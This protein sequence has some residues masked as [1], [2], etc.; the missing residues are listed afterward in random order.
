MKKSTLFTTIIAALILVLLMTAL[1]SCGRENNVAEA[2]ESVSTADAL[3]PAEAGVSPVSE[4]KAE[5]EDGAQSENAAETSESVP[6][7]D[8]VSQTEPAASPASEAEAGRTAGERFE[9]VIVLEGMEETVHYEHIRNAAIGIEMD[10]DYESFVRRSEADRECFISVWDD[11]D[12][13]E[14]SLEV[15]YSA[16]DAESVAAAI[17]E[18]LSQTYDLLEESRELDRAGNC[19]YIEAS[20]LKGTGRMADQLQVVYIIPASDGCRV[21]TAHFSA[22]AAEGFGRRFSYMV[23]TLVAVDRN[24]EITLSDEQALSAI[25]NYCF[26]RNPD[27]EDIIS[28]GEYRHPLRPPRRRIHRGRTADANP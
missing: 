2:S 1:C 15:K 11:T 21:A 14:N 13:P 19:I 12:A 4:D 27:L 6:T 10:Y 17:R 9:E 5:G 22:E 8:P 26:T 7:I 28:A 24:D 25:R 20:E 16:E 23:N 3:S 18:N